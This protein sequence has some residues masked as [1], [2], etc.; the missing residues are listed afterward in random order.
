LFCVDTSVGWLG[1]SEEKVT[2][3]IKEAKQQ[4]FRHFKMKAGLG[5]ET[6]LQRIG[7]VR[8]VG[9]EDA[10][11]MID[12]NGVWDVDEAITYMKQIESLKPWQ[13]V[14]SSVP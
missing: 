9:G 2:K 5:V 1:Q 12:A 14:V 7:L 13:V 10:V 8:K 3:L 4:G 6:D 11:L